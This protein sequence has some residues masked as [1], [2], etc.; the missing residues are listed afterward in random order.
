LDIHRSDDG[1][2]R[3]RNVLDACG[4][5]LAS[6]VLRPGRSEAIAFDSSAA[7]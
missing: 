5:H 1:Q 2:S 4:V 6:P 3:Q 7:A